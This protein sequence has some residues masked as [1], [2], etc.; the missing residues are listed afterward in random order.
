MTPRKEFDRRLKA[1][2]ARMES[3]NLDLLLIYSAPG[4][5]RF[6]QRG[7]VMYVSGHEPYFGD[8]MVLLP[9]DTTLDPLL[10]IGAANHFSPLGSWIDNVKPAG[11]HIRALKE[12]LIEAK[13]QKP[14]IGVVGEYSMSPTFYCRLRE[15]VDAPIEVASDIL[16]MERAVKSQYEIDCMKRACA[17]AYKGVQAAAKFARPGVL[18]AEI[19]G[20]IERVCRAAGSEFFPHYT[21][22]T[23]GRDQNHSDLWGRSGKRMLEAGDPWLLDFGT[24]AEGYCCDLARPFTL[25]SPSKRQQEVFEVLLESLEAGRKLARPG[26]LASEVNAAT[27]EPL[28]RKLDEDREWREIGHG[29]GLEVHEWPFVGYGRIVDDRAYRDMKLEAGMVISMEPSVWL[30]ETG[31]LQV[32]DQFVVTEQGGQRLSPIPLQIFAC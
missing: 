9:R 23:S 1:I 5:L 19:V 20:E 12:Y 2:R 31:D 17:I 26:V 7:H 18:E 6:G 24:M 28:S 30:P 21:M 4:S 8:S 29:V 14:R 25:G 13:L 15:E 22:A 10:E 27:S 32:E 11:D 3:R 16:E